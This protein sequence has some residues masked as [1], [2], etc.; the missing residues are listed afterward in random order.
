MERLHILICFVVVLQAALLV[1]HLCYGHWMGLSGREVPAAAANDASSRAQKTRLSLA[2]EVQISSFSRHEDRLSARE[3]LN[4][5]A[6]KTR[7]TYFS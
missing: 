3:T 1:T 2:E 5:R 4:I 7:V 6:Q